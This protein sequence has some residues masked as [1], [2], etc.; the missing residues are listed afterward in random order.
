[1]ENDIVVTVG[2]KVSAYISNPGSLSVRLGDWNPNKLDTLEEHP[3]IEVKVKCIKVHPE[4]DLDDTLAN[5][6]AILKLESVRDRDRQKLTKREKLVLDVVDVRKG[7]NRPANSPSG[8]KGFSKV[9]GFSL[10]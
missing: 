8:V 9:E 3:H 10:L 4:A 2:H 7:P 5:N 6:V 1:M